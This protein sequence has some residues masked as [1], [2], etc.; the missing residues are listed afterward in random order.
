MKFKF[1]LRNQKP[2]D[3]IRRCGYALWKGKSGPS[4]VRRL[5]STHY[6][7]FHIYLTAGNDFFEVDMHIDQ[8]QPSYGGTSA[9][10]GEYDGRVVED[11]ARRV[12]AQ[13]AEIYGM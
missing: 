11:E 1:P 6:P 2:E 3:L 4:Y 5:G 13:I 10:S 7:R 9:H 8:K 12:T